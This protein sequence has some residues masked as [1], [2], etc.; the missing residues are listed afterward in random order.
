MKKIVSVLML[1]FALILGG[2]GAGGDFVNEDYK[3]ENLNSQISNLQTQINGLQTQLNAIDP[4]ASDETIAAI[5]KLIAALQ[6]QVNDLTAELNALKTQ[7]ATDNVTIDERLT[8]LEKDCFDTG[9][10]LDS[11]EERVADLEDDIEG[12]IKTGRVPG[13]SYMFT[14]FAAGSKPA[15]VT[16]AV[17]G[18]F[19]LDLD[20]ATGNRHYLWIFNGTDWQVF[21]YI[22]SLGDDL[23]A[24]SP[25]APVRLERF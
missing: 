8:K 1:V 4:G 20:T 23:D 21:G 2:C 14:G 12:I 13:V 24:P 19:Y 11:L 7:V 5:N 15:D 9:K 18:D 6:T 25:E 17:L 16:G 22:N 3:F 10:L